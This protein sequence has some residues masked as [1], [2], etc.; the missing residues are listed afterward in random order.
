MSRS[1]SS[2]S[3]GKAASSSAST[4][5]WFAYSSRELWTL[6]HS[7]SA[8]DNDPASRPAI[9]AITIGAPVLL[10]PRR[11]SR[12]EVRDEAVVG[13]EHRGSKCVAV[14]HAMPSLEA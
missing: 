14:E 13:T 5:I 6:S 12:A 4:A 2:S 8:I 7:P 9:P 3:S 10:A 11:P 1:S